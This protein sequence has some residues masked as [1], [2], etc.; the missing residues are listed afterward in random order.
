MM[1]YAL[2]IDGLWRDAGYAARSLRRSAGFSAAAILTLAVGIG[3]TTA[4]CSVVHTVLFRPLPFPD[5]GRLVRIVE[6]ARPRN[7]PVISY[8][9]FLE[10]RP[11][12]TTLSGLAA[13]A[14]NPQGVMAA[15]LGLVRVTGAFVSA[16]YFEVLRASPLIGRT[17]VSSDASSPYVMVLAYPAWRRHFASDP[18][19]IGSQIAFRSGT[20]AGRSLTVVGV[21]P[22]TLETIGAPSDF[23][24]PMETVPNAGTV[25]LEAMIGRLR[26]GIAL[27][28]ASAE[29]NALG[30]AVRPPRGGDAPPLSTPRFEAR[31]LDETIFD[32][33][34]GNQAVGGAAS[35]RAVLWVFLAAVLVLLLIVCANVANLLLARGMARRREIATRLALGASRW[36]LLRQISVEC[37]ILAASGGAIGGALGAAGIFVIKRLVT[38]DAQGVF[39]IVFGASILPRGNELGIDGRLFAIA[40]AVSVAATFMFGLPSALH[41]SRTIHL[42]VL[43]SRA[44]S[45]TRRDSRIRAAVV[46]GE[47]AMATVLLVGA[48]LLVASFV[49]LV[50]VDK[51]YDPRNVLAFQLVLPGE[52]PIARKAEAVDGVLRAVRAIPD[53]TAAGFAYA[54]IMIGVQ[55]TVGSF[56]P[57]GRTLAD[58]SQETDRPRLKSISPGYLEAAGVTV[59]EG[60]LLSEADATQ[61]VPAVLVNRIVQRRYFPNTSP[62]GAR[63]EWHGFHGGHRP[64]QIVGVVADVRQGALASE[65]YPEIFIDYRQVIAVQQ[66]WG[67]PPGMVQG[68]AFGFMSF[69]LRTRG[70]PAA[71]IPQVKDAIARAD[72]NA[73]LDAIMPMDSLVASSIA[74][75]RFYAVMLAAFAAVAGLLAAIGIYGVLAYAVVEQTREI[76]VRMALGA[77]PRQVLALVLRRGLSS[78]ALGIV[79]GLIGAAAA[80]RYLQAILYGITPLDART[81]AVVAAGFA[82]VAAIASYLPARR[83]TE[84]DPMEALRVD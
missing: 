43:R 26:D 2:W 73:A 59:L 77:Q 38:V 1:P 82:A 61:P 21:M 10:W 30:T 8:R 25:A 12:A 57:A 34:P 18:Q 56:V 55:D 17:L 46:I 65:P 11:R 39:R 42:E 50:R 13:S 49:K 16:N 71:V 52:Y 19:V 51:G 31:A 20:L 9:E 27:P 60:R 24:V 75:Q 80:T 63:L 29:A 45:M 22:E 66:Q 54:G 5:A 36:Q 32:P 62:I 76:G 84:V 7:L 41:L 40:F 4:I 33:R 37:A 35:V 58:I 47:L 28:A 64:V 53:V 44:A 72:R 83:A 6:N 74:R 3:A 70:S 23:Y 79:L 48:G 14:F 81:F 67:A 69:A 78:T 68:L 15:P